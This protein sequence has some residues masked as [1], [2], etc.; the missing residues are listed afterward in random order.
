MVTDAK[1]I[2]VQYSMSVVRLEGAIWL[3]TEWLPPFEYRP[4][5][6]HIPHPMYQRVHYSI[7]CPWGTLGYP[8]RPR[9][10]K[11]M[12]YIR[13]GNITAEKHVT[14]VFPLDKITEA[15]EMALDPRQSIKVMV[16]P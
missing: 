7:R 5:P 8:G 3:A 4:V 1:P 10:D 6:R 2:L 13:S 16:E 14:H 11:G 15:Y 9:F 12:E